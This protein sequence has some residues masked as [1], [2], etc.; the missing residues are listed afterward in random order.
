MLWG[1]QVGIDARRGIQ[2]WEYQTPTTTT[3]EIATVA[4]NESQYANTK[5][6]TAQPGRR[7]FKACEGRHRK[8]LN[9]EVV[10]ISGGILLYNQQQYN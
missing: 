10:K 8:F 7:S 3:R 2:L 5:E 9:K 6:I 1:M 4:T